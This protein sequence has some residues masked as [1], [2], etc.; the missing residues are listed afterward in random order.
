VRDEYKIC[1]LCI[2]MEKVEKYTLNVSEVNRKKNALLYSTIPVK[3]NRKQ[4]III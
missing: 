3:F 4:S 1:I 2:L